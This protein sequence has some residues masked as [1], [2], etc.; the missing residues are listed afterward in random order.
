M[1][2]EQEPVDSVP[3][4]DIHSRKDLYALGEGEVI[5]TGE[6]IYSYFAYVDEKD[7]AW[8][9]Q[10]PGVRKYDLTVEILKREL[11]RIPDEKIYPLHTWMTVVSEAE[12]K[13][14]YI[15]RPKFTRV[16]YEPEAELIP[17]IVFEEA[18]TLE[19]LNQHPHPNIVKYHGCTV[20]RGR[21]TGLALEKY[22]VILQYRYEDVP[23][24]LDIA[25]CMDGIRAGVK[26]L[27][28][29]GYAHND[30][31][32]MNIAIDKDD[33]PIILDFGSSRKFGEQLLTGGTYGWVDEDYTTSA[34]HHDES[35][36]DKIEA[37]LKEEK[38][39][40]A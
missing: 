29:L 9:G 28:S 30:L 27:H 1:D 34:Q 2:M 5:E 4:P 10:M 32:P 20:N 26:H 3:C 23:H 15:K 36:M 14:L 6:V 39:K 37:W 11:K 31:N 38:R 12:R 40:R 35:A 13:N 33:N 18:A 19:F 17:R 21:I 24:D 16:S 25:A 22:D 8:V 7:V